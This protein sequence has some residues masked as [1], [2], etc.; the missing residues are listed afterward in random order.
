MK[1]NEIFFSIGFLIVLFLWMLVCITT[2]LYFIGIPITPLNFG[3]AI[4]SSYIILKTKIYFKNKEIQTLIAGVSVILVLIASAF[5]GTIFDF[6]WDG[7]SYQ[8]A[9]TGL[10]RYGW[11]PI[12]MTYDT[13]ANLWGDF[14]TTNWATWYDAYPKASS[15]IGATFYAVTNNIETGKVYTLLS[16]IAGTLICTAYLSEQ[17]KSSYFKFFLMTMLFFNP[18]AIAQGG[19][20]YN[21]AFLWNLLF[22]TTIACLYLTLSQEKLFEKKTWALIFLCIGLGVNIKFSAVIYFAMICGIFYFYWLY[23]TY[24]Q[25]SKEKNF[26][27]FFNILKK[28]TAFYCVTLIFSFGVLGSTSYIKNA[29]IHENPFYT[30][31]GDGKNEIIDIQTP[32]ALK[33]LAAGERFVISLFSESSNNKNQEDFGLKIPLTVKDKETR[34]D[35]IETRIGGWGV[36]F[37]GIW[38]ISFAGLV[39]IWSKLEDKTKQCMVMVVLLS[40]IPTL[41]VPGLFWARYWMMLFMFPCLVLWLLSM[42]NS[43]FKTK[44]TIGLLLF[45]LVGNTILPL[46]QMEKN[47]QKS[48]FVRMEYLQLS[49]LSKNNKLE[50]KL[51]GLDKYIFN[52]LVFNLLD[53]HINNY[54]FNNQ[55]DSDMYISTGRGKISYSIVMEQKDET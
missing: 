45:L 55:L 30:M 35:W 13:A 36:L 41:F 48:Q 10:L 33:P 34:L 52:G 24:K 39:V 2:V 38:V 54:E 50:I 23:K 19:T 18:I 15:I 8:K 28:L 37:S 46:V 14:P 43:N 49:D 29:I 27:E 26:E 42:Y 9:V 17:K 7:N 12:Y 47:V 22:I 11:N 16:C 3:L 6:S 53:Y 31:I 32:E 1:K 20:F 4:C 21:D 25:N 44:I 51:G 40:L 5:C